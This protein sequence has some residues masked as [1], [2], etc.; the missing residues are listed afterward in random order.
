LAKRDGFELPVPVSKL[1]YDSIMLGFAIETGCEALLP[2]TAFLAC[3][4]FCRW[5]RR[6]Q[7]GAAS[8]WNPA[9]ESVA[10]RRMP[11]KASHERCDNS[12]EPAL[13]FRRLKQTRF[14]VEI[15]TTLSSE[16][17]EP[18]TGGS[19]SLRSRQLVPDFEAFSEVNRKRHACRGDAPPHRHRREL[20]CR[21]VPRHFDFLS[22][23]QEFGVDC[24]AQTHHMVEICGHRK[25]R[26]TPCDILRAPQ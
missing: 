7:N 20:T 4:S 8:L 17:L 5:K 15:N 13:V 11:E 23:G 12:A 10:V 16:S 6:S 3:V 22:V 25:Q 26:M 24:T 14:S 9:A 2:R 21:V 1:S 18:G 19:N